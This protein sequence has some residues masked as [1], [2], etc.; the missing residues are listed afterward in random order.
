VGCLALLAGVCAARSTHAGER[1]LTPRPP[2]VDVVVTAK[3]A[4]RSFSDQEGLPQNTVAAQAFDSDGRLWV[5]TQEGLAVY[6]GHAFHRVPLPEGAK[7]EWVTAIAELSHGAIAVGTHSGGLWLLAEGRFE[8]VDVAEGL[9]DPGVLCLASDPN[10]RDDLWVGT[11]HGLAR[12]TSGNK[13]EAV[14]PAVVPLAAGA[15]HAIAIAPGPAGSVWIAGDLGVATL[16]GGAWH[17]YPAGEN[18]LPKAHAAYIALDPSDHGRVWV[19]MREAGLAT[20]D[21]D[22]WRVMT[23]LDGLPCDDIGPVVALPGVLWVGTICGGLARLEGGRV[24]VLDSRSSALKDNLVRSLLLGRPEQGPPELWVGTETGG[25]ARV[26]LG[27]WRSL[28]AKDSP[29]RS[30]VYAFGWSRGAEGDPDALVTWVGTEAGLRR[31]DGREWSEVAIPGV[32]AGE[33]YVNAVL[34]ARGDRN[35]GLWVG[36]FGGAALLRDGR[37]TSFRSADGLPN[38]IVLTLFE[39][40]NGSGGPELLAGMRNGFARFDGARWSEVRDPGAPTTEEVTSMVETRGPGGGPVLWVATASAGLFRREAGTWTHLAAGESPLPSNEVLQVQRVS[41]SGGR[42]RL[43]V[44]TGEAGLAWFDPASPSPRWSFLSTKTTPALPDQ[45]VYGVQE[46]RRGRIYAFT[47]HGVARLVE[48]KETDPG[49]E[50]FD[51]SVVTTE[52]GLPS[53]ECNSGGSAVDPLGRV[54]AGTVAGAAALE[55]TAEADDLTPKRLLLE[56]TLLYAKPFDLASHPELSYEE[57]TLSFEL[58]LLSFHREADSTFRTQLVGLER[59]PSGW[60]PDSKVRYTSLP[61]GAYELRAWGRDYAGNVSGPIRTAFRVRPAPWR[62]WWAMLGYAVAGAS[63]VAFG[64]RLRVATLKQRAEELLKRV[65]QR[66]AELAARNRELAAKNRELDRK[67]VALL[68]S[69]ERA[70]RIFSAFTDVLPGSVLDDKYR[71]EERIGAGGFATVF[72]AQQLSLD[73]RVA[74]KIFRPSPG[75]DS[76]MALDRFRREGMSACRVNHPNAIQ[77]FDSGISSDGIPYIVMELL[78]GRA[79]SAEIRK[80]GGLSLRRALG[81]AIPVCEA[82][83]AAHEAGLIHRDIKPDNIFIA[84][85]SDGE[86]VKLLDFGIAKLMDASDPNSANTASA[87]F[88][89]TPRYMAP[90]RLSQSQYGEESDI[91]SLGVVLYEMILGRAPWPAS[92][93]VFAL[94]AQIVAGTVVPMEELGVPRA[95]SAIV[96]RALSPDPEARVTA[97]ELAGELSA[98]RLTLTAEQLEKVYGEPAPRRDEVTLT[99]PGRDQPETLIRSDAPRSADTLPATSAV[100]PKGTAAE[101]E[102]LRKRG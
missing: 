18:G 38:D 47:N 37:W 89:G 73:R 31:Y 100:H 54:W 93:D 69:N 74:V 87:A 28:T 83:A 88:V 75:N 90:E 94:V 43:F 80:R 78:E 55:A 84:R 60:T 86:V 3:P 62:T 44:S 46:D 19:S 68:A 8:H 14:S 24:T 82:L 76:A 66:T 7:S 22:R 32:E 27:G 6:D 11:R 50:A 4:L 65:D 16:S 96:M 10:A 49:P 21:G 98:A 51:V 33:A 63:L 36:T 42:E 67:N 20:L 102:E 17:S 92:P 70:D 59:E 64:V 97:M 2:P 48:T 91:Y 13:W 53:N 79:L 58:A 56:R 9:L 41:I 57:D 26:A 39:A 77:I 15:V 25:V 35:H 29:I 12:R 95:I 71:I 30:A 5:G 61:A 40:T 81:I 101:E 23:T 85:S 45:V 99:D 1:P 72:R 52:D 34:D